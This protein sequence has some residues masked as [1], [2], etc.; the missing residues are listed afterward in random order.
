ML[1]PSFT[2]LT[3]TLLGLGLGRVLGK[4]AGTVALPTHSQ[5][6]CLC[7]QGHTHGDLGGVRAAELCPLRK[8]NPSLV[9]GGAVA[10]A[11]TNSWPNPR[12][13]V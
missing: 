5:S 6:G 11:I 13:G 2:Q 1:K 9:G 8:R 3:R 4:S 12:A 7:T 10:V